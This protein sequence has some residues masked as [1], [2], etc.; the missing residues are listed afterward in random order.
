MKTEVAQ[1]KR[2]QG[3]RTKK[4]PGSKVEI[5]PYFLLM[6]LASLVPYRVGVWIIRQMSR[7]WLLQRTLFRRP[8]QRLERFV[9]VVAQPLDQNHAVQRHLTGKAFK[10]LYIW[11]LTMA[12]RADWSSLRQWFPITGLEQLERACAIGRGVILVNSHFG[13]GRFVPLVLARRMELEL[14][15]LEAANKFE[16]LG[17]KLPDSVR[18]IPLRDSFLARVVLQAEKALK[19]GKVVHL[20]ADGRRGNSGF[21]LPFHGRHQH[22]A[23]G[24]AELAVNTGAVVLPVFAPFDEEGRVNIE[25]LEPLD[26]GSESMARSERVES[27]VRQYARLLELRWS[28][29]PGNVRQRIAGKFLTL[30]VDQALEGAERAEPTQYAF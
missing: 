25:L 1:F 12:G 10:W 3:H 9:D 22:F 15:S 5:D 27:L 23:A 13:G 26:G 28:Q 18:V 19:Q 6:K 14:I 21:V 4:P 7:S 20:A 17:V 29:D 30:P 11:R 8:V 16:R 24:F 2:R